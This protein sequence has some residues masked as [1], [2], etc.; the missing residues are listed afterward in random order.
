MSLSSIMD[1]DPPPKSQPLPSISTES[2]KLSQSSS[3]NP[4]LLK[5]EVIASPGSTSRNREYEAMPPVASAPRPS[6]PPTR[7]IPVPDEAQVEAELARIETM[8][9]S[10]AD[11]PGFEVQK[12]EYVELGQKRALEVEAAEASKRKVRPLTAERFMTSFLTLPSA[13]AR[14]LL[15]A[16]PTFPPPIVTPPNRATP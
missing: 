6:H 15:D 4:L 1:A 16:S 3:T 12:R 8:E 5:Q 11:G 9:M 2:R 10:D 14:Q 7:D 13:D